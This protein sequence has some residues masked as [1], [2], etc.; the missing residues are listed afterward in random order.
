MHNLIIYQIREVEKHNFYGP[1]LSQD[2]GTLIKSKCF[3]AGILR[4]SKNTYVTTDVCGRKK[5]FCYQCCGAG[6]GAAR[7]RPFWLEPEPKRLRS[8][9]SG[10]GSG[11]NIK[12]DE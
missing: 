4:L 12:E 11:S 7:S 3:F 9:G 10:S 8:F 6:A 2:L 5:Y 1:S